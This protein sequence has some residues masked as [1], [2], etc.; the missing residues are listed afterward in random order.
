MA[1]DYV[2]S[3]DTDAVRTLKY[4]AVCVMTALKSSASAGEGV[5]FENKRLLFYDLD[6]FF[7]GGKAFF[8]LCRISCNHYGA[9]AFVVVE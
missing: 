7:G 3:S 2:E 5:F 9:V 4:Y 8:L 6:R 1:S